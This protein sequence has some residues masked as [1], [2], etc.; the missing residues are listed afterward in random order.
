M[1]IYIKQVLVLV[2]SIL[3]KFKISE[4]V[5]YFM[6]KNVICMAMVFFFLNY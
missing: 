5:L 3:C 6:K 2:Y 4:K 1:L